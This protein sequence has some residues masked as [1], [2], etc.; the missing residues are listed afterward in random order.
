MTNEE[1]KNAMEAVRL[2]NKA[3]EEECQRKYGCSTIELMD[4]EL[5]EAARKAGY[6]WANDEDGWVK[7]KEKP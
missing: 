4:H 6:E 5:T 2:Q 1:W 3:M 7:I